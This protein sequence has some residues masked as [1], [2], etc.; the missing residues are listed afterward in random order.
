VPPGLP[1]INPAMVLHGEQS[2]R[3][4]RPLPTDGC[5]LKAQ[6]RIVVGC[7]VFPYGWS[8]VWFTLDCVCVRRHAS[9]RE[10]KLI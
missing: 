1:V 5:E 3:L 10:A 2:I 8:L 9:T 7:N 4:Y 6:S